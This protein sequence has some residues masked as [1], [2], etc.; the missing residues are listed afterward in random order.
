MRTGRDGELNFAE[1]DALHFG[2]MEVPEADLGLEGASAFAYS[3]LLGWVRQRGFPHLL[4][5]WNYLDA[6]TEGD[7][8][9]ERYRRFCVGRA[10]GLG[11]VAVGTLP[12]ATA[13]GRRDGVRTLQVYWLAARA[14]GVPV[15]NPRQVS[16]YRYPRQYGP[17]PPSF[18]RAATSRLSK[19]AKV[20][21]SCDSTQSWCMDS[22]PT[23][24]AVPESSSG[25]S[26]DGG[27]MARAKLGGC[28]P[29]WRG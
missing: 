27:S 19:L 12:A 6:I 9:G 14:P 21:T 13:I 29:Y 18:A 7:N 28:G 5:S 1:D 25:M 8:D 17:Q 16:A 11:E 4:R 10:T 15:E 2:W 20:S 22:C 26:C 23:T 3:R 24:L